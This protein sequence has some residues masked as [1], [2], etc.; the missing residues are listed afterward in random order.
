[1]D[2]DSPYVLFVAPVARSQIPA[3]THV[4]YSARIETVHAGTNALFHD[5]LASFK[6]KPGCPVLVN[7]S[8][9]VRGEPS[10]DWSNI[11]VL[12]LHAPSGPV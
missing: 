2:A 7:A 8:F 3:V 9:N 10:Y 4:D 11:S 5:L 1:M 6:A 12:L